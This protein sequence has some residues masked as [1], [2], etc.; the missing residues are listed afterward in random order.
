VAAAWLADPGPE[1]SAEDAEALGVVEVV[2][3]YSTPFPHDPPRTQNL[4]NGAANINGT[5]VLPGEEFSLLEALGPI[6]EANGY[7]SSLVVQNGI[8]ISA[9]GGGPSQISPNVT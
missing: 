5:L 8:V 1:F 6:T 7:V 3:E 2:G 4:I 9:T